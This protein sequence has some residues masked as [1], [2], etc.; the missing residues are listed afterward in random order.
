MPITSQPSHYVTLQEDKLDSFVDI[1][2]ER[3]EHTYRVNI[4]AYFQLC[5]LA[6]KHFISNKTRGNIINVGSIQAYMPTPQILDYATTKVRDQF[7]SVA[8]YVPQMKGSSSPMCAHR[9][10]SFELIELR[11][12]VHIYSASK[13]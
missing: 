1:S 8:L 11:L 12:E 13:A 7:L 2:F 4:F 9:T 3:L 5:Q 6:V 10:H